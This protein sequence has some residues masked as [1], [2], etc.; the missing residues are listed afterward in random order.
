MM[1]LITRRAVRFA[2]RRTSVASRRHCWYCSHTV[3]YTCT[4]ALGTGGELTGPRRGRRFSRPG[5][6]SDPRLSHHRARLPVCRSSPWNRFDRGWRP[7]A[8]IVR[9]G[10]ARASFKLHVYIAFACILYCLYN[11]NKLADKDS[12]M[13]AWTRI[14]ARRQ[15]WHGF[16]YLKSLNYYHPRCY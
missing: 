4:L 6:G 2:S 7:D 8:T 11:V 3:L 9:V 10:R 16:I 13:D 5:A 15:G 12:R 1:T 14:Y